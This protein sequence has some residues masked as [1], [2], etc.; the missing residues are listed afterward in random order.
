VCPISPVFDGSIKQPHNYKTREEAKKDIFDY[1]EI[2]YN[3][4]RR[5][6]YLGNITAQKDMKN[7]GNWKM[8]LRKN[9][10]FYLTTSPPRLRLLVLLFLGN[11]LYG[12]SDEG[13]LLEFCEF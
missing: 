12:G 6:S 7:C 8:Q 13:G 4:K 10:H 9:V 1:I 5:H 2:F 11:F 3:N